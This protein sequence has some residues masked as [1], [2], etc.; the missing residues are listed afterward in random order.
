MGTQEPQEK[1]GKIPWE[2]MNY[3]ATDLRVAF[4]HF[5]T[6]FHEFDLA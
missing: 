1:S 6:P 3:L 2:Q 4:F 5:K